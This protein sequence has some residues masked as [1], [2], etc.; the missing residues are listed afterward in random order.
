MLIQGI[1]KFNSIQYN[2]LNAGKSAK[3]QSE[4]PSFKQS[5]Y[6]DPAKSRDTYK[7][8]FE[9]SIKKYKDT[10]FAHLDTVTVDS[11][12]KKVSV[13]EALQ[14]LFPKETEKVHYENLKHK[15]MRENVDNIINNGFDFSKITLTNYGPGVYFGSEGNIQI[16]QGD[17]LNATFDGRATTSLNIKNYNQF[18]DKLENEVRKYLKMDLG[19]I[20]K[21]MI[22]HEVISGTLNEYCRNK[23]VN[24]LGIDGVVAP[25]AGYFV[26]FNPDSIT[27][28]K[29]A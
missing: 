21:A 20:E 29:R 4:I 1:N 19:D 12:G 6:I 24:E 5:Q 3:Q 26:V 13:T 22:E 2:N 9:E 15:T 10:L 25:E 11:N 16:Y 14:A 17:T 7:T 27:E 18:R 28:V 23:I 8:D